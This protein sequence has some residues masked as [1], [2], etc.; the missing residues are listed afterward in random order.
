RPALRRESEA[1]DI[2]FD[3][4]DLEQDNGMSGASTNKMNGTKGP[5][6]N[7]RRNPTTNKTDSNSSK[8]SSNGSG[9]DSVDKRKLKVRQFDDNHKLGQKN[10]NSNEMAS[11]KNFENVEIGKNESNKSG[12]SGASLRMKR[13]VSSGSNNSNLSN[14]RSTQ[15]FDR[16][17]RR[18]SSENTDAKGPPHPGM[19]IASE[20]KFIQVFIIIIFFVFILEKKKKKNYMYIY[21]YTCMCIYVVLSSVQYQVNMD[22][23]TNFQG[24]IIPEISL[25]LFFFFFFP[26]PPP[27]LNVNA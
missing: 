16:V 4:S 5:G 26:P 6:N 25:L 20:R 2:E 1:A 22:L 7:H 10:R 11:N 9:I 15:L 8:R 3:E 21:I 27:L 17:G 13:S 24:Q 23:E 19:P 14:D 18:E 12:S